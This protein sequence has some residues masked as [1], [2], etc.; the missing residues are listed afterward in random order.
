MD[1]RIL[2]HELMDMQRA[3]RDAVWHSNMMCNYTVMTGTPWLGSRH[4]DFK[5]QDTAA[6]KESTKVLSQ[7]CF[8]NACVPCLLVDQVRL[9]TDITTSTFMN[10]HFL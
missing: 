5:L 1:R 7:G 6:E 2:L 9:Q 3:L 10:S 4:K 8:Y